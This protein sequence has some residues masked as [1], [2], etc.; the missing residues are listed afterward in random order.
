MTGLKETTWGLSLH[1]YVFKIVVDKNARSQKTVLKAR[2][3]I[4][5]TIRIEFTV[6]ASNFTSN[7]NITDCRSKLCK[8]YR[9]PYF[10]TNFNG[11]AKLKK[12]TAFN[13]K[14]CKTLKNI[15]S[16]IGNAF[17]LKNGG[18]KQ[19]NSTPLI[20]IRREILQYMSFEKFAY[21]SYVCSEPNRF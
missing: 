20:E 3:A 1:C 21:C 17:S 8:N 2:N 10:K 9:K 15:F 18:I 6:A 7:H 12:D 11:S 14:H 5:V 4:E 19:I 16:F 13:I